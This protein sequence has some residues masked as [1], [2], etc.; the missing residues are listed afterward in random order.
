MSDVFT[1]LW[2]RRAVACGVATEGK[3]LRA[4]VPPLDAKDRRRR[5][6]AW[7][8]ANPRK[9]FWRGV[10]LHKD[11]SLLNEAELIQWRIAESE[12]RVRENLNA[13]IYGGSP[14]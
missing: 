13:N 6:A 5:V 3:K 8:R 14:A 2:A 4:Y 7:H 1:Y 11:G 10:P 9:R 12:K